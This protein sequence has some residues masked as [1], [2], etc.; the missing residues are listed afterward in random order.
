MLHLAG[1]KAVTLEAC[2]HRITA[3]DK[4]GALAADA[5]DAEGHVGALFHAFQTD[6]L[7][8][9]VAEVCA[10]LHGQHTPRG[11]RAVLDIA[12]SGCAGQLALAGNKVH[13]IM[14]LHH[15]A[16]GKHAGDAGLHVFVHDGALG[17]G[18]HLDAGLLGQLVFGDQP[19]A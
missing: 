10:G 4:D 5:T 18:V 17:A 12:G 16:A 7:R 8:Q 3:L 15:V 11:H 19:H 9:G 2:D 6:A 13:Q 14:H 1:G